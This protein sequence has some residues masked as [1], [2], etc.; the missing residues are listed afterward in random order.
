[1]SE[2]ITAPKIWTIAD[3]KAR[4]SELLRLANETP[5]Y[6]GTKKSY[7]LISQEKWE[8]LNQPEQPLGSWLVDNLSDC[9]DLEL[10]SRADP[11]REIPFQ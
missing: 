3:A 10:P 7:V 9:G 11:E 5:Q 4:L 6:I 2:L 1:M 8:K